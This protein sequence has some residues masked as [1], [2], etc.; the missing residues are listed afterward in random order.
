MATWHQQKAGLAGLY[1]KPRKGY[2]VVVNPPNEFAYAVE[3]NR[4]RLAERFARKFR[5]STIIGA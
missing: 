4:K 3:F 1:A 5:G 2:R